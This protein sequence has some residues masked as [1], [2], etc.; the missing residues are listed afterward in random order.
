MADLHNEMGT[1]HDKVALSSGKKTSLRTSR[2]AIRERTRKY[3][4]DKLEVN[5]PKFHG[6]G[7]FAMITTINPL[8]GE[9]DIDDGV[10]L[11]HLDETSDSNWPSPETVHRWLM[12]STENQTNEKSIDKRTCVR[13]RYAG[14]YHV[15]L[16]AYAKLNGTFMLAEKGDKGWHSSDSKALTEW[17]NNRIQKQ[18]EQLR[19]IVRY[20]KAWADYQSQKRGK[21]P[22]G[23]ILTVL[24]TLNFR[25]HAREDKALAD[26]VAAISVYV[27]PV[28]SVLNPVDSMEELTSRLSETQKRRFQ[29]A[30]SDFASDASEAINHE[31]SGEAS[32]IWREQ[33]GDRF[34]LVKD[35]EESD[36]QQ[37]RKKDAASLATVYAARN[38]SKPWTG[39]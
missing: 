34:P 8:D 25:P 37:Q 1:Y 33:L 20:L 10:Y 35:E 5:A 7:S 26:T 31:S 32:E 3:F 21:M 12:E 38:P 14:Q 39:K 13:V 15:D 2:D 36:E 18:G 4:R 28:F 30:I 22:N 9:F 23:L 17:F 11:Q 29:D 19:R 6:Q 16:P 24:A 27:N